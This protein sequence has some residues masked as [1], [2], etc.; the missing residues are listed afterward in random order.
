MWCDQGGQAEV[1]DVQ[2][3][4]CK[5]CGVWSMGQGSKIVVQ[6][7][8]I[9]GSKEGHGVWC[10][11]GGQAEVRGVVVSKCGGY[12]LLRLGDESRLQHSGCQVSGCGKGATYQC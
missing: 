11:D 2:I 4:D 3:A 10:L 7:G 6:G 9:T 12:G 5:R 8:R 1:R